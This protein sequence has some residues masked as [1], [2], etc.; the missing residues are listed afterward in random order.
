MFVL[1][2]LP[3]CKMTLIEGEP[4]KV[5]LLLRN[6]IL[7]LISYTE[8]TKYVRLY[9]NRMTLVI[10]HSYS[11]P[12]IKPYVISQSPLNFTGTV[13]I[14]GTPLQHATLR[15]YNSQLSD[16]NGR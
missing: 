2:Y 8:Y 6:T 15:L 7:L 4:P 9:C 14:T 13:T 10:I 16:K 12:L 3:E 1:T 5:K 11:Y